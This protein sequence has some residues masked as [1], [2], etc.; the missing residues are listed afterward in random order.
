MN[1]IYSEDQSSEE[2]SPTQE[3]HVI[4]DSANV[5]QYSNKQEEEIYEKHVIKP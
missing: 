5:S 3:K 4:I 1:C 2:Y